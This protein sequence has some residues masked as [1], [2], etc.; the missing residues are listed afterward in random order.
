MLCKK[1]K[2]VK[3]LPSEY[4]NFLEKCLLDFAKSNDKNK[5]YFNG[6]EKICSKMFMDR[7]L[8]GYGFHYYQNNSDFRTTLHEYL[9]NVNNEKVTLIYNKN[10]DD[11][12]WSTI[13]SNSEKLLLMKTEEPAWKYKYDHQYF[14]D[15]SK[16]HLTDLALQGGAK[17]IPFNG[18][19]RVMEYYDA[20]H[21][22]GYVFV[23]VNNSD[24]FTLDEYL[25]F[26]HLD[27]LQL[28]PEDNRTCNGHNFWHFIV[29]PLSRV[30]KILRKKDITEDCW[31]NYT[32]NDVFL[33]PGQSARSI[34]EL[35]HPETLSDL[36]LSSILQERGIIK[37]CNSKSKGYTGWIYCYMKFY[38]LVVWKFI[39]DSKTSDFR[40]H[41]TFNLT[42]LRL[43][44]SSDSASDVWDF[45]LAPETSI[46]KKMYAV[47]VSDE[48]AWSM[49]LTF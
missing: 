47:D 4:P 49:T 20:S 37:P 17:P 23:F 36:Q 39:N 22:F 26:I 34:Q 45:E 7:K 8:A 43:D 30:T 24:T 6:D 38:N 40:G 5:R 32:R 15:Y 10:N 13:K 29:K 31:R 42:N 41:F 46:M 21:D 9:R 33:N 12:F 3:L 16:D 48:Y 28:T 2:V 35:T 27:N 1:C 18:Q 25:K 14:L 11:K 19:N 44:K